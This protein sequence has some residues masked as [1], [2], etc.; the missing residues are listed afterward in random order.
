MIP[1]NSFCD[2]GE[3]LFYDQEFT[4]D[5]CPANYV[6]F[7]ALRDIYV[8]SPVIDN[9]VS[10]E[11]MKERYGLVSTW[12]LYA[13]EEE[14]FQTELRQRNIYSGFY[15][16]VKHLFA[17]VKENRHSVLMRE[18]S[19]PDYFNVISNLDGRRT[20]L[21]GSG[22]MAEHYLNKYGK[23]YVPAFIADNN[24]E[25][26]GSFKFG[27]E[28][29]NP[30]E[31]MKLMDGSYRVIITVKDYKPIVEQLERM[32]VRRE[33][34]RIYNREIDTLL[35]GKWKAAITDGRYN[36]S[37]TAGAFER[38]D[39]ECLSWLERCKRY[40]HYLVVGVYTD[41]LLEQKGYE[42]NKNSMEERLELVRQCRYVDRVIPIDFYNNDEIE[43]WRELRFGCFFAKEDDKEQSEKIW[44]QRKLRSLGCDMKILNSKTGA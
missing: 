28:I 19:E 42:K 8:F 31:I 3:I 21:F 18:Q 39:A 41:E 44:I 34:Y 1:V 27:I 11:Y 5:N 7:R 22:K 14:R 29:K 24:R 37:Y 10:L 35:D 33:N 32:E 17:T 13:E 43:L 30:N 2:D 6:M 16:W 12:D 25:K 20:I 38:F 4:K 15:Y 9:Y 40:S 23:D 36:I 26:W